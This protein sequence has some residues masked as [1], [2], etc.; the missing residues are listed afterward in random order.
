MQHSEGLGWR[1][2]TC[3]YCSPIL[4][5][6]L[7]PILTKPQERRKPKLSLR[8][9]AAARK[10]RRTGLAGLKSPGGFPTLTS[11]QMKHNKTWSCE[12]QRTKEPK[13]EPERGQKANANWETDK[14]HFANYTLQNLH[15]IVLFVLFFHY[16]CLFFFFCCI[17]WFSLFSL[18]HHILIFLFSLHS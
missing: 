18:S 5:P 10:T 8:L 11:P 12:R 4:A 1:L 7:A 3:Q 17:V 15:F 9:P 14:F 13:T 6:I 16:F 2:C